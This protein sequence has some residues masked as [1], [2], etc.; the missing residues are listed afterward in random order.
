[1]AL[2]LKYF[3]PV[4]TQDIAGSHDKHDRQAPANRSCPAY[5]VGSLRSASVTVAAIRYGLG[6]KDYREQDQE[7]DYGYLQYFFHT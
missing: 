3:H 6:R 1:M 2:S 7:D 4:F 5:R